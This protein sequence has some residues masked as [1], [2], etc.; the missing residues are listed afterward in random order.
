MVSTWAA[1]RSVGT[2]VPAP[3]ARPLIVDCAMSASCA[4]V[5]LPVS[6][7]V[8]MRR[9]RPTFCPKTSTTSAPSSA[10]VLV[11]SQT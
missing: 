3:E 4:F 6:G 2:P 10:A 9:Q 5:T 11:W 1:L 8:L 7:E